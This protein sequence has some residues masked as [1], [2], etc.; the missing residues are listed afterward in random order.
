MLP[1]P[2]LLLTKWFHILKNASNDLLCGLASFP[3][4]FWCHAWHFV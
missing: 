3:Y 1:R 4:Y 2:L